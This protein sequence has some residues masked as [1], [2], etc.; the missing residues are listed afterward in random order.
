MKN[1]ND[2]IAS[3]KVNKHPQNKN[4]LDSR[5]G[6][7]QLIKN[8]DKTHNQKEKHSESKTVKN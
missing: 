2:K 7:E 5:A 1:K 6:E 3:A 8:G 4:D